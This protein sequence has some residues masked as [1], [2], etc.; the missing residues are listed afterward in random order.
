M[1]PIKLIIPIEMIWF[2]DIVV[3]HDARP[4]S[5]K[6]SIPKNLSTIII[7]TILDTAVIVAAHD[8]GGT[9][10]VVV[11]VGQARRVGTH[12]HGRIQHQGRGQSQIC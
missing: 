6:P 11:V 5:T 12:H 7:S 10:V 9:S 3:N 8:E 2:L 4:L 1:V